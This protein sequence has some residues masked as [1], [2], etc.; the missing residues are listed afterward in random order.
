MTPTQQTQPNQ[1]TTQRKLRRPI[2]KGRL[3]AAIVAVGVVAALIGG[4][5]ISQSA[6]KVS[7]ATA[8]VKASDLNVTVSAPGTVD[9]ASRVGV[10]APVAGTLATVNVLEGQSVKAGDVLATLDDA[11]L[12]VSVAQADAA[13]ASARAMPHDTDR[14]AAA[15]NAAIDAAS[16][17]LELA[18]GNVK[19]ATMTAPVAGTVTFPV[20]AI[21]SLDGSGPKAAAGASVGTASP[22]FT[23]VDLAKVVF[24]AQVDEA[25]V[26]GVKAGATASVTLD[27]YPGR[28][29]TGTVGEIAVASMATKTGGTA[30]VVKVPLTSGDAALRLGMSGDAAISTQAISGA[31]VVP[32]QAVVSDGAKKYV[33]KVTGGKV[34]RAEVTV[35]A[36]TDTQ[37]Q[38]LSGLV[39]GDVVA[40]T[41]LTSL[42]DGASVN[43]A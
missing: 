28:P 34:A 8:T 25:D 13:L 17:A 27:A 35:G 20:L 4:W 38:V 24:A 32:A 29:F 12:N 15:R 19:R 40:T 16:A 26:A 36:S 7:V 11:A 37:T 33:Y 21:T 31:L 18:Q 1:P 30:F 23:I 6:S 2:T 14:Q 22:V 41:N 10:Y 39:A 5:A 43:V 3:I 42:K 9:A